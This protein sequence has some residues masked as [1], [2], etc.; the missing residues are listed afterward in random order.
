MQ[1]N[2]LVESSYEIDTHVISSNT[3]KTYQS[4]LH[5]YETTLLEIG[6]PN[7]Y[8][9]TAEKARG[10]IVYYRSQH[11]TTTYGYIRQFVSAFS[12]RCRIIDKCDNFT[13]NDQSFRQ[14]IRGLRNVMHGG[15]S[16]NTKEPISI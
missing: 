2:Q 14:F 7:P 11:P 5:V 8:P 16:P 3:Q 4:L 9:C 1:W 12:Y 6:G 10:F 13:V 15:N